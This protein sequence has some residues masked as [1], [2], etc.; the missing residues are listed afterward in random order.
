VISVCRRYG[1]E[2]VVYNPLAGGILSGKYKIT[3]VPKAGRCSNV[4]AA[5]QLYRHRYFKNATLDTLRLLEPIVEQHNL[6]LVEMSLRWL[7]HHSGI[8]TQCVYLIVIELIVKQ[9]WMLLTMG[10]TA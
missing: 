2:V 7:T 4:Y 8:L 6:T 10:G 3:G 1:I 5:E 9:L